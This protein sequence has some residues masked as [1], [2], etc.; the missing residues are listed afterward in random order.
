M[1]CFCYS[2]LQF[3]LECVCRLYIFV[4][5]SHLAPLWE[6]NCPFGFPLVMFPLGSSYFVF[7]FLSLWCL[8]WEV[9]ENC[10]GS[11]LLPSL[12]FSGRSPDWSRC[13][14]NRFSRILARIFPTTD[15]K[16]MPR[17]LSQTWRFPFLLNRWIIVASLNSWGDGLFSPH[18]VK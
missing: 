18:N 2:S 12:L 4:L 10:I 9:W 16:K 8:W 13:S 17:W 11:W 7:V 6:S 1:V 3:V 5:D 15:S 14:Y